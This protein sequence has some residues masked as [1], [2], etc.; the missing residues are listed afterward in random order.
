MS[1]W[2]E[3]KQ[4]VAITAELGINQIL[5]QAPV[6]LIALRPYQGQVLALQLRS[7]STLNIRFV[8]N[9]LELSINNDLAA[10]AC[11]SGSWQEFIQLARTS[12]KADFLINSQIEMSG[13]SDLA[14]Q[15]AKIM[16]TLD[17]DWEAL[18]SPV[19]GGLLAHQ[20][21]RGLRAFNRYGQQAIQHMRLMSKSYLEDEGQWVAN[22]TELEHF[23]TRVDHL[24][25][26][27]DRL[28]ARLDLLLAHR[29]KE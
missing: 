7:L 20:L 27:S 22:A 9:G 2:L 28:Q 11:L 10:D 4:G 17:I 29:S 21:G 24:K 1:R 8:P 26:A 3:L 16:E 18:I 19:T 14:I 12:N 6:T 13:N 5:Q 25:L 15:V 23:A